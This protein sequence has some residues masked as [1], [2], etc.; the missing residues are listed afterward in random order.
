MQ[1]N[2]EEKRKTKQYYDL[3]R[4]I[5][6]SKAKVHDAENIEKKQEMHFITKHIK[7]NETYTIN[8]IL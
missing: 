1:R 4:D 6:L 3:N 7:K 8:N 2:K 5:I